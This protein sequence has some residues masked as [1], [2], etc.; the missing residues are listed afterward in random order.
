MRNG[1]YYFELEQKQELLTRIEAALADAEAK[2]RS[3]PRGYAL[4]PQQALEWRDYCTLA[5][6]TVRDQIKALRH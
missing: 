2:V 1:R 3:R 5:A 6:A 4:T